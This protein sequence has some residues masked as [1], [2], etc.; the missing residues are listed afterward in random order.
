MTVNGLREEL[1]LLLGTLKRNR[2]GVPLAELKTKYKKGYGQLCQKIGTVASQYIRQAALNGLRIRK[3]LAADTQFLINQVI[4]ES[5][6]KHKLSIAVFKH[7]DIAELDS[8]L[9]EL[10]NLVLAALE[11][12]YTRQIG[13]FLVDQCFDDPPALPLFY[14]DANGQVFDGLKWR[15]LEEF[16]KI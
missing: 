9:L 13:L 6:I 12:I 10:R 16:Q 11:P 2:V 3:D 4:L 1:A 14:N 5:G 7:C 8:L 15:P